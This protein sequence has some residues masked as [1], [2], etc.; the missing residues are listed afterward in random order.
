MPTAPKPGSKRP[1]REA[2]NA[3]PGALR[4]SILRM[5]GTAV[6]LLLI[7]SWLPL[8]GRSGDATA[9]VLIAGLVVFLALIVRQVRQIMEAEHPKLRAIEALALVVPVLVL[10]FAYTYASLSDLNPNSF[11]EPVNRVDGVYFAMTILGTVGFG[12]IAAK[13]ETARIIVTLQILIGLVAA[14]GLARL[15]L[16]AADLGL[17]SKQAAAA[18]ATEQPDDPGDA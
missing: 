4:R 15:L 12:D 6:L 5:V 11:T 9:F 8:A 3:K 17:S 7:Y 16:G 13:T 1:V 18:A 2:I 14:V 10:V